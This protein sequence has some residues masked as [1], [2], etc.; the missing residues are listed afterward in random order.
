MWVSSP[1]MVSPPMKTSAPRNTEVCTL[2]GRNMQ[3]TCSRR[4]PSASTASIVLEGESPR[5]GRIALPGDLYEVMA[6]SCKIWCHA[7]LDTRVRRLAVEYAREEYREPMAAALER[8]K[9]KLG[10]Q[11][12]AELAGL[13]AAWDI[14][15]LG[16]GLI[17]QYYDKLYYKNR[18]WTPDVEIDLEDFNEAERHLCLFWDSRR[19]P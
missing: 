5:I 7:S 4:Q 16:R 17:E 19:Q 2:V 18:P 12:Y 6:A 8:I 3:A 1:S 11:R 9:K 14:E 15:G 13:L 10:G